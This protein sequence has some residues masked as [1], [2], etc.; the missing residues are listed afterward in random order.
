MPRLHIDIAETPE[1]LKA[2]LTQQADVRVRERLHALYLLASGLVEHEHRLANLLARG[3][4]T[5][6]R[7]LGAYRR[8]GLE[9]LLH[10]GASTGRPS[11]VP[12]HAVAALRQRLADPEQ[13]FDS[14]GEAQKWLADTFGV[15]ADYK[16]VHRLI[17]YRLG[18]SLRVPRPSN[19]QQDPQAV[20]AFKKT[21]PDC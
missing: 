11:T 16:L 19:A 3:E 18:S 8:G 12:P 5:I 21:S 9:A 4:A 1:Q 13:G 20:E 15:E 2:L 7:W 6:R 10:R 14:Y 17:K